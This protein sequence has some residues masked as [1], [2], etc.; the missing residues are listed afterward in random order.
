MLFHML[1][2]ILVYL[3]IFIRSFVISLHMQIIKPWKA[4]FKTMENLVIL[5][6]TRIDNFSLSFIRFPFS[7]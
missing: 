7:S 2:H 5:Q 3:C 6:V 1:F 4:D